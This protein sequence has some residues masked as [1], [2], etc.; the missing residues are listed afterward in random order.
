MTLKAWLRKYITGP[1]KIIACFLLAIWFV[2]AVR[3]FV[4]IQAKESTY[5]KQTADLLSMA[6]G[7]HNRVMAESVLETLLS[8]GGA[9]GA[10]I[11]EGK[12]QVIGANL[13]MS[14][15]TEPVTFFEVLRVRAIPGSSSLVLRAKFS[16]KNSIASVFTGLSFA[17]ILVFCGFFFIQTVQNRI[18]KDLFEPLLKNLL[19]TDDLEIKELAALRGQLEEARLLESQKAVTLAIQ[20][21]NQQVAHDIRG[22]VQSISALLKLAKIEDREL[23]SAL[24]KA[25]ARANSV[26]NGLLQAER[27]VDEP[28]SADFKYDLVL[29][30]NEIAKEKRLLF[31]GGTIDVVAPE[32]GLVQSALS[33]EAISRILSNLI[34]NSILACD[35]DRRITLMLEVESDIAKITVTDAGCGIEPDVLK[36]VG[37]K[38]YSLRKR[39]QDQ[40][41]GRGIYSAK[42]MLESAGGS[43]EIASVPLRGTAVILTM[44]VTIPGAHFDFVLVDND[45]LIRSS[46]NLWSRSAGYKLAVFSS[47]ESFLA[48]SSR[49][50]HETP[51]FIDSDL[52]DGSL[53]EDLARDLVRLGFRRLI[54]ATGYDSLPNTEDIGLLGVIGK[55]PGAAIP[56]LN[57]PVSVFKSNKLD[58][59]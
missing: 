10:E 21:N 3:S 19:G 31:Y 6:L 37:E 2:F 39:K 45:P 24:E 55:D 38:G 17:L 5:V 23:R 4:V 49:Y 25:V 54:M 44:P 53:G 1:H 20:E 12:N 26:A 52:G 27:K 32:S 50:P 7:Q 30:L 14:S 36:R 18:M 13:G 57:P 58:F 33:A 22:P 16:L 59:A 48:E 51:I 43:L 35:H 34:D 47:A 28:S 11:C 15:C 40:G 8:Q 9:V 46:W 41:T 42:S 29:L 56:F